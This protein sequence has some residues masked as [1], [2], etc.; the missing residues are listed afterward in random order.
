MAALSEGLRV[1][2]SRSA[3]IRTNIY[4]KV[5]AQAETTPIR[6]EG[7]GRMTVCVCVCQRER[8]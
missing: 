4:L 3:A 5:S 2:R 8:V 7:T 1:C 6:R